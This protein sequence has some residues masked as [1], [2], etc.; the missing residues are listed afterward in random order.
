MT[1]STPCCR[2]LDTALHDLQ[3]LMAQA[4]AM[5]DLA[6]QFRLQLARQPPDA[7]RRVPLDQRSPTMITISEGQRR[8]ALL[9]ALVLGLSLS[10]GILAAQADARAPGAGS[11]SPVPVLAPGAGYDGRNV[12]AVARLQRNMLR[13]GYGPGPV[14]GDALGLVDGERVAERDVLTGVVGRE[15][16]STSP[17]EVVDG[18]P[19]AAVAVGGAGRLQRHALGGHDAGVGAVARHGLGATGGG[20][21]DLATP[22]GLALDQQPG[23]VAAQRDVGIVYR[24]EA[25]AQEHQARPAHAVQSRCTRKSVYSA[26]SGVPSAGCQL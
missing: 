11:S 3:A 15:G 10:L 25:P 5:V 16:G 22:E 19:E 26:A 17:A 12:V 24:V 7:V 18:H 6:E 14:D 4:Q 1:C 8:R 21:V 23:E 2:V 13:L 9:P 20:E